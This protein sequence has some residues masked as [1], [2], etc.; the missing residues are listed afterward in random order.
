MA[1]LD[2]P[3][4]RTMPRARD[5]ASCPLPALSGINGSVWTQTKQSILNYWADNYLPLADNYPEAIVIQ[6]DIKVMFVEGAP[7]DE[8]HSSGVREAADGSS[9]FPR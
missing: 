5:C 1:H 4:K 7:P 9:S 8:Q 2:L 6:N 3:N